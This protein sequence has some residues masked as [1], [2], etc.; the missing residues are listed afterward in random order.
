MAVSNGVLVDSVTKP[1]NTPR[2][3]LKKSWTTILQK[4]REPLCVEA[5]VRQLG[6]QDVDTALHVAFK[7]LGTGVAFEG[8]CN[9]PGG[10]WSGISFRWNNKEPEF[11]WLT[12]PRVSGEGTKDRIMFSP[13]SAMEIAQFVYAL[14]QKRTHD[15]SEKT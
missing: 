11:R 3:Y 7:L 4:K 6:E 12:L 8:M 10:D 2:A 5:K 15:C 14:N 9:P 1:D 13:Y